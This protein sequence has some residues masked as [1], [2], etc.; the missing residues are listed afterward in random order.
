MSSNTLVRWPYQIKQR[1]RNYYAFRTTCIIMALAITGVQHRYLMHQLFWAPEQGLAE[2]LLAL[3][4]VGVY[5]LEHITLAGGIATVIVALFGFD[6]LHSLFQHSFGLMPYQ[7]SRDSD[8]RTLRRIAPVLLILLVLSLLVLFPRL[9][10][11]T[12]S[13]V[14]GAYALISPVMVWVL[15]ASLFPDERRGHDVIHALSRLSYG[16]KSFDCAGVSVLSKQAETEISVYTKARRSYSPV[17][18]YDY[19]LHGDRET[20]A[21]WRGHEA[22]FDLLG[23]YLRVAPEN[24]VLFN[25][26][27]EAVRRAVEF[28]RDTVLQDK[29][30]TVLTTD[31]E[32][33]TTLELLPE[34]FGHDV[35]HRVSIRKS[36][37]EGTSQ[38]AITHRVVQDIAKLRPQLIALSHVLH[39]PGFIMPI[40]DILDEIDKLEGD[41]TLGQRPVVLI[42][43][44]QAIG[45]IDVD[46]DR[47]TNRVDVYVTSGHKWMLGKPSL[48]ILHRNLQ[49]DTCRFAELRSDISLSTKGPAE[50]IRKERAATINP[51]PRITLYRALLDMKESGGPKEIEAHCRKLATSFRSKVGRIPRVRVAPVQSFAGM[52]PAAF[53]GLE[54]ERVAKALLEH[55]ITVGVWDSEVKE[56]FLRIGFHYFHSE[57]DV[58]DL[59][60]E[61]ADQV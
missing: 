58:Y 40:A 23:E 8:R 7:S 27:T 45:Q 18:Q 54:T 32:Y 10:L 26:T 43:G 14:S 50:T 56:K 52:C 57:L 11:A 61:L 60:T 33:S 48:G 28:S 36:V 46:P 47:I 2:S 4:F 20:S 12:G 15:Y 34:T 22:F 49:H 17:D 35:V 3:K 37:L 16:H 31:S 41:K 53:D 24:L 29:I 38:R 6:V 5:W 9:Q 30:H 55:D 13:P 42:D 59:V 51:E 25:T 39:G 19:V 44:A 1:L 21:R